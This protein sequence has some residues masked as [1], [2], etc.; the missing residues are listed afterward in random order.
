MN[1]SRDLFIVSTLKCITKKYQNSEHEEVKKNIT[2]KL[3]ILYSFVLVNTANHKN[4]QG[5]L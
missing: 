1:K 2:L 4:F 3:L 5:N